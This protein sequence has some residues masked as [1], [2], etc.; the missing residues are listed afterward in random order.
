MCFGGGRAG[1]FSS[2][3]IIEETRRRNLG[4]YGVESS[5]SSVCGSVVNGDKCGGMPRLMSRAKAVCGKLG[6]GDRDWFAGTS[7]SLFV[8]LSVNPVSSST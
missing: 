8:S 4:W 2:G 5:G 6:C 3:H 7:F 1:G